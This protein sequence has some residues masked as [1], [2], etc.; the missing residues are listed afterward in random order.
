MDRPATALLSALSGHPRALALLGIVASL[1]VAA[2]LFQDPI[3]AE[4]NEAT[5]VDA[6]QHVS[7]L[8]CGGCPGELECS[9]GVFHPPEDQYGF[10]PE[11]TGADVSGG[12]CV[13][14][15]YNERYCGILQATSRFSGHVNCGGPLPLRYLPEQLWQHRDGLLDRIINTDQRG[16]AWIREHGLELLAEDPD[17]SELP[18]TWFTRCAMARANITAVAHDPAASDLRMTVTNT[19]EYSLQNVTAVITYGDRHLRD[20]RVRA[21]ITDLDPGEQRRLRLETSS[22]PSAIAIEQPRCDLG[23]RLDHHVF[24]D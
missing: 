16:A 13:T 24:P 15:I 8:P 22:R 18:D 20:D 10:T 21:A 6:S 2:F 3:V 23:R 9:L 11:R 19:G 1:L 17:G 5:R 4:I 14:P 12:M 7:N